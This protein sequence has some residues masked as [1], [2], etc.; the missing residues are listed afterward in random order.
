M[1]RKT[2]G[3]TAIV[4]PTQVGIQKKQWYRF[5]IR[6][7][8]THCGDRKNRHDPRKWKPKGFRYGGG[9]WIGFGSGE[10]ENRHGVDGG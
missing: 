10:R 2:D 5:P 9:F 6:S 8:M 7:G 4:I 3:K 1:T